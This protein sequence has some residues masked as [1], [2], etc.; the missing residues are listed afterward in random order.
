[1]GS[2]YLSLPPQPLTWLGVATKGCGEDLWGEA[3]P[4][5]SK[6]PTPVPDPARR[7]RSGSGAGLL[8]PPPSSRGSLPSRSLLSRSRDFLCR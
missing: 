8:R 7:C 2:P 6:A 5:A 3:E 4:R 1:M